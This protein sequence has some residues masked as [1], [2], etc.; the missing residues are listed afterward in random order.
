MN[1][2]R[3]LILQGEV[4]QISLMKPITHKRE[5]PGLLEYLEDIIGSYKYVDQ[6]T[7]LNDSL[8]DV[9]KSK[10]T[11][12]LLLHDMGKELEGM[13]ESK[14]SAIA[15]FDIEK[16]LLT[17]NHVRYYLEVADIREADARLHQM[18]ERLQEELEADKKKMR[19]TME[20]YKNDFLA[21]KKLQDRKSQNQSEQEAITQKIT[22]TSDD[23]RGYQSRIK[24]ILTE[25]HDLENQVKKLQTDIEKA[26]SSQIEKEGLL[27]PKKVEAD[28]LKEKLAIYT[29]KESE[30]MTRIQP[31]IVKIRQ[32]QEDLG[33]K[34]APL[35]REMKKFE[36]H[37]K[38]LV[39][40]IETLDKRDQQLVLE[41]EKLEKDYNESH[42]IILKEAEK[43]ETFSIEYENGK[44]K[45]IALEVKLKDLEEKELE[46][47]K[48]GKEI[49]NMLEERNRRNI[50][51]VQKNQV[52]M[53][54][55]NSK[56]IQSQ[57][58]RIYGRIGDLGWIDP[59]F[60]VAISSVSPKFNCILVDSIDTMTLCLKIL[61]KDKV[62]FVKM[63]ALEFIMNLKDRMREPFNPPPQSV[64][65]FDV[66]KKK[67][68]VAELAF[69]YILKDSI[70]C[71][72]L[73]IAQK[74]NYYQGKRYNVV[75][76]EGFIISPEGVMSGGGKP[77]RGA[78]LLMG[79]GSQQMNEEETPTEL[80]MQRREMVL[81]TARAA[82]DEYDF[83]SKN[84]AQLK[85][86]MLRFPNQLKNIEENIKE[87]TKNL[88]TIRGKQEALE[89]ERSDGRLE[90]ARKECQAE[91]DKIHANL[92]KILK[93]TEKLKEKQ[94]ELEVQIEEVGGQ[95]LKEVKAQV[96]T[97]K[98]TYEAAQ[99]MVHDLEAQLKQTSRLIEDKEKEVEELAVKMKQNE[100][101]KLN[102]VKL[103]DECVVI[104][105]DLLEKKKACSAIEKQIEEEFAE[106]QNKIQNVASTI[107]EVK[108]STKSKKEEQEKATKQLALVRE[109]HGKVSDKIKGNR[110]SY[111]NFITSYSMIEDIKKIER[112]TNS[113]TLQD[114]SQ[115]MRSA[116]RAKLNPIFES[117]TPDKDLT[118]E[119]LKQLGL[120]LDFVKSQIAYHQQQRDSLSGDTEVI[121]TYREK[122][123]SYVKK[124]AEYRDICSREQLIRTDLNKLKECRRIEFMTGFSFISKKLKEVYQTITNGGDADLELIDS[125][126]P[127]S[128]GVMFSVRPPHKS[129][130]HMSKLSGGE[131]TLSSLSLIFALHYYKPTPIY[132]MDEIDA[133]LDFRNVEIV[134][135][136]I[137][138]RT[139]NAQFIVI[140]L[141]NHMF[142]LSNQLVGIYK[143][144]DMT[145][146]ISLYPSQFQELIDEDL[147][148][149]EELRRTQ[150]SNRSQFMSQFAS[151]TTQGLT[152]DQ[153]PHSQNVSR[154]RSVA[155]AL[156]NRQSRPADLP[157][158]DPSK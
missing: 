131:K 98:A 111:L 36:D 78:V 55:M 39:Q 40:Q 97:Y 64:R 41:M 101:E 93:E 82:K 143:V 123:T 144:N 112:Q 106:M 58:G 109:E 137:K 8:V 72:N 96:L 158:E 116:T 19:D 11:E 48:Q 44:Q 45:H 117:F 18:I 107:E 91:I 49:E 22:K 25:T 33:E 46:L 141:R 108:R 152:Q 15:Y 16:K 69:Y 150:S 21:M 113:Q 119:D 90:H 95:E 100:E 65:L 29:Q 122:L 76:T 84:I 4:E 67:D 57:G 92:T 35:E 125:L 6:I 10:E 135:K 133:A 104:V 146:T 89:K 42:K 50:S 2:N 85:A 26:K 94:K 130:K 83:T 13:A 51:G 59:K 12:M 121:E 148:R 5:E 86:N 149:E 115:L 27:P 87:E 151:R 63:I 43:K 62:G 17:L 23:D 7:E 147:R 110:R 54:L 31:H 52:L 105:S 145:R 118:I 9:R 79:Q 88:N 127:F 1:N 128:E 102:L 154:R 138:E 60:D 120:S 140:S 99:K 56:E 71:D 32:Q 20:V 132:F 70:C 30:I 38:S 3:F 134:G 81:Q 14:A 157:E 136:F 142:E 73:D 80:L 66:V 34:R 37:K 75:T 156:K 103:K 68:E 53:H 153:N 74:V 126:D 61:K 28:L 114:N 77:K 124:D 155:A 139:K 24:S 47:K 129:W